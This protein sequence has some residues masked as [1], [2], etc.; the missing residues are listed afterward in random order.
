VKINFFIILI[1]AGSSLAIIP[2]YSQSESLIEIKTA[3]SSYEQ[4]EPI[5]ISGHVNIIIFETPI[6]LQIF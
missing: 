3:S 6:T 5:I 4:G 2:I 1:I